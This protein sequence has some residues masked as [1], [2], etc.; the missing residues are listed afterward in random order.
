MIFYKRF[1][2]G[3]ILVFMVSHLAKS[4]GFLMQKA[5]AVEGKKTVQQKISQHNECRD[6][7][8][9]CTNVASNDISISSL[10]SSAPSVKHDSGKQGSSDNPVSQTGTPLLLPF[11]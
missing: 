9:S 5:V 6:N 10:K 11:P 3:V 2:I 1:I 8:T 4:D 7:G